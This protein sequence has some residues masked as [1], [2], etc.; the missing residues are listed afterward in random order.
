MSVK[1]QRLLVAGKYSTFDM[2]IF[3]I[4]KAAETDK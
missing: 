4:D 3:K 2:P 1:L